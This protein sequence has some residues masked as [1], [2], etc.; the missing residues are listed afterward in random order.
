[1][2][3]IQKQFQIPPDFAYQLK[4]TSIGSG[5]MIVIG[6]PG[7]RGGELFHQGILA[8]KKCMLN[9]N[10]PGIHCLEICK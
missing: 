5:R 1:M 4:I 2:I 9:N 3:L 6:L 10:H 7:I 8:M